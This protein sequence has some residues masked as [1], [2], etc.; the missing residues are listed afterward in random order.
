MK[1]KNFFL[2]KLGYPSKARNPLKDL[3]PVLPDLNQPIVR[4]PNNSPIFNYKI[5]FYFKFRQYHRNPL[6]VSH[7]IR[8]KI[9]VQANPAQNYSQNQWTYL[10]SDARK[11]LI[12]SLYERALTVYPY[13]FETD[14]KLYKITSFILNT[15]KKAR[16]SLIGAFTQYLNDPNPGSNITLR[17]IGKVRYI[18]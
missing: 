5:K 14:E 10:F 18:F 13:L 11:L 3:T 4:N 8:F 6:K 16:K 15:G 7:I 1:K 12:D 9:I 2:I 17:A